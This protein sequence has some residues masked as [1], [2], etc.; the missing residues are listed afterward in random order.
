MKKL[1]VAKLCRRYIKAFHISQI[2]KLKSIMEIDLWKRL[3]LPDGY[4]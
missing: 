2:K 1:L 3:P 4:E